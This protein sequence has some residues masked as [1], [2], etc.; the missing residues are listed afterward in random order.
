M[1][2]R[3]ALP[4]P[5]RRLDAPAT[6][7]WLLGFSLIVYLGLNGGGY[8]PL[9]HDQIGILVWW[10]G[11]AGVAIGVLP[12][13]RPPA[14][15]WAALGLLAAFVVWTG[16][17]LGWTESTART[18]ADL[19]RVAGY[20]GIFALA[21]LTRVPGDAPRLVGAVAAGIAVVAVVALLSRLHPAWFPDAGQ[22]AIFIADSRERLSYP[23]NYWNGLAAL[24]A[25]G[26]PL[27]LQCAADTRSILLRALAAAAIPA[28]ALTI[29]L[30]LSR[31]GI[32]AAAIALAIYIALASDR[33]PKLI[34]LAIG[35][36]GSGALV[37]AASGRD[38]LQ[39][40]LTGPLAQQQG[41][42]LLLIAVIVCAFA[43][44]LQM[45]SSWALQGERRP[46]W[47]RIPRRA[48]LAASLAGAVLVLVSAVAV[49]AP[50]RA[51]D[52]WE[53]FKRGG[54]PGSG[55]ERL[56]SVAGQSRYQLWQAALDQNAVRPLAG[57]GSGTF[58]LWWARHGRTGESVRDTHSL[59]L[60]TLGE[61]GIV[62]LLL[63]LVFL[64]TVFYA[65]GRGVARTAVG[66]PWT[67]AALAG[68]AAFCLTAVVD[69]MWQIPV[70]AVAM[71]LLASHLVIAGGPPGERPRALGVPARAGLALAALA[72]IVAIAIPLTSA[73]L[74]RE[75]EDDFR[76][77]DLDGALQAARSAQNVQSGSAAP[78]LQEALV[79]EARGELALATAA[80][81]AAV[82]REPD[83]WRNWLVF[84][85]IDA[86][87]GR[88]AASARE[89]ARARSLNPESPVFAR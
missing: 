20:L 12:R 58:E 47:T 28:L 85:R 66:R 26:L 31:G 21:L 2:R 65:G 36:A 33:L 29:F 48:A 34:A 7:T 70:L 44:L 16:L 80:A 72:A 40:G 22:T 49:D 37:L 25:I 84:S 24:V 27:L 46:R 76:G 67:A 54:G 18:S 73:A 15:A 4:A 10:I 61:L 87:S 55:T 39:E 62:G 3:A 56:N 9:V 82:E 45:A 78:R 88:A 8:D 63:L 57:A 64:V 68:S 89:Y 79:L 6:A 53:E 17:S 60:Q 74:L 41:D 23:V 43:G 30:T 14:L 86:E 75:S 35:G 19:A 42:D 69:W 13:R 52:G 71:L 11:F 50:G 51:S 5:L 83:N 38:A 59:Y 32:A 77:G 1:R 81:E